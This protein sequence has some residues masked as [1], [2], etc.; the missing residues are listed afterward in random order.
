MYRQIRDYGDKVLFSWT[1]ASGG[2]TAPHERIYFLWLDKADMNFKKA[3][4]TV[5]KNLN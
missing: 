5:V 3:D 4:G 1:S 2:T